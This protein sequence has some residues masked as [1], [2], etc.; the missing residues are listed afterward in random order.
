[1]RIPER[2]RFATLVVV[3][4][5]ITFAVVVALRWPDSP[6]DAAQTSSATSPG[7]ALAASPLAAPPS[8][9][10]AMD[11]AQPTWTAARVDEAPAA[12]GPW[13]DPPTEDVTNES[14]EVMQPAPPAAYFPPAASDEVE[15]VEGEPVAR[16][17]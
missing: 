15:L 13:S 6:P 8:P 4:S 9:V 7:S 3:S 10:P 17:D 14:Q 1:M 12:A 2:Y 11:A 5:A 16:N